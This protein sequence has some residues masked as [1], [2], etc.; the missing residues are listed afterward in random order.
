MKWLLI[1]IFSQYQ[2]PGSSGS[3]EFNSLEACQAASLEMRKQAKS[4]NDQVSF[5]VM[6][7]A[8]KGRPLATEQTKD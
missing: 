1:F 8:A 4:Y 6:V 7:C 2:N 5:P 3:V